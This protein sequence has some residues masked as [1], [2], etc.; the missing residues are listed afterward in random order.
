[1]NTGR[2]FDDYESDDFLD[3]DEVGNLS[4]HFR[5][6]SNSQDGRAGEP[7][8]MEDMINFLARLGFKTGSLSNADILEEYESIMDG[9]YYEWA[10]TDND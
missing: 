7:K 9:H 8:S 5:E 1:M 10:D 2:D 6:F 3:G 4:D